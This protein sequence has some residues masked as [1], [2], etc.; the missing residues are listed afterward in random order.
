MARANPADRAWAVAGLLA[1]FVALSGVPPTATA[2]AIRLDPL[3]YKANGELPEHS[4]AW[5]RLDKAVAM[6]RRHTSPEDVIVTDHVFAA[7]VADRR[8]PP[9]LAVISG[10]RIAT[11]ALTAADVVAGIAAA[12]PAAILLWDNDR[13]QRIDG[14]AEA[15]AEDYRLAESLAGEWELWVPR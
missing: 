7:F 6:V 2:L 4:Q 10:K 9:D 11:G 3:P 14:V 13:L 8:V 1:L 15:I 5:R 12:R